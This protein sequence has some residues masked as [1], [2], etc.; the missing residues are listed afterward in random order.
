MIIFKK[1]ILN[2][3]K[4]FSSALNPTKLLFSYSEMQSNI[5]KRTK[6]TTSGTISDQHNQKIGGEL[7]ISKNPAFLGERL[8][9]FDQIFQ[10]QKKALE[11]MERREINI[12]L[13]DGKVLKGKSFETTPAEIAKKISKK[14]LESVVAC[15]VTYTKKDKSIFDAGNLTTNF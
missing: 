15:R 13:K 8:K 1:T 14:L 2:K 9:F 6:E 11:A 5:G 7:K 3:S 10:E 4:L 12:V